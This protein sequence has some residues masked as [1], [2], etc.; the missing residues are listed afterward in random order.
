MKLILP[1]FKNESKQVSVM[2]AR[3]FRRGSIF[4]L[5]TANLFYQQNIFGF[6]QHFDGCLP[7]DISLDSASRVTTANDYTPDE[8]SCVESRNC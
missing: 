3:A 5:E 6:Q 1:R 4:M 8:F 7:V 2:A